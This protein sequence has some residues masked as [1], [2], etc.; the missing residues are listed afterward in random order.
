MTPPASGAVVALPGAARRRVLQPPGLGR[1]ERLAALLEGSNVVPHPA[2][3]VP[4]FVRRARGEASAFVAS[5]SPAQ[6]SAF[7]AIAF[8]KES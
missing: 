2:E 5:L 6:R 1:P 4:P 3:Y 7:A 8:P